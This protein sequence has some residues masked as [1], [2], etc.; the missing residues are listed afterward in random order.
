VAGQEAVVTLDWK[1]LGPNPQATIFRHVFDC[2]GN[3]LGMADGFLLDRMVQF[4]DLTP[5]VEVRDVRRIPLKARSAD[6]C[7]DLKVGLFREDGTRV[8]A[9]AADGTAFA[10]A[11]VQIR[12]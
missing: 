2:A 7:Y 5:G 11:A 12:E 8:N 3:V 9:T 1:Y 4:S 6:G 10:D